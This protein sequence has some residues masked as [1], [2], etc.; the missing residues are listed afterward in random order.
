LGNS[1]NK[2]YRN[3]HVSE[4]GKNVSGGG[5]KKIGYNNITTLKPCFGRKIPELELGPG[6]IEVGE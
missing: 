3:M 6:I 5:D 1:E 2:E 4:S